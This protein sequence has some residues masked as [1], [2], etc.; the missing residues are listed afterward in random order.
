MWR[1]VQRNSGGRESGGLRKTGDQSAHAAP[2]GLGDQR[3]HSGANVGINVIYSGTV[4]AAIE[5]A[6]LGLPAIAIRYI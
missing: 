1:T 6:F 3:D 4:A 2:A 5:A